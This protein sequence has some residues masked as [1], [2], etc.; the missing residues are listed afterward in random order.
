M[1]PPS[2][3]SHLSTPAQIQH[4]A[5]LVRLQHYRI[6]AVRNQLWTA[7]HN[8]SINMFNCLQE[9][10]G[11]VTLT[12]HWAGGNCCFV[13][14]SEYIVWIALKLSDIQFE[15]NVRILKLTLLNKLRCTAKYK[16]CCL[17]NVAIA[18]T[19]VTSHCLLPLYPHSLPLYLTVNSN[20]KHI[21]Q[22]SLKT[23]AIH[24]YRLSGY[25]TLQLLQQPVFL[26]H[27]RLGFLD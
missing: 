15:Q 22:K 12:E 5:G 13:G 2:V 6:T 27:R 24:T 8:T 19:C 25:V 11:C 20:K 14:W 3:A 7:G 26:Q 21:I 16:A 9:S 23:D 10:V 1:F 17:L 4:S 18:A